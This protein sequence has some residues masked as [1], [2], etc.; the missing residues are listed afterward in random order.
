VASVAPRSC[1]VRSP[2]SP[3][4]TGRN[5][6]ARLT[7]GA[8]IAIVL[9]IGLAI[10]VN[11]FP[12]SQQEAAPVPTETPAPS[13][14]ALPSDTP[15]PATATPRA[16]PTALSADAAVLATADAIDSA[17]VAPP[18]TPAPTETALPVDTP[19]PTVVPDLV[20]FPALAALLSGDNNDSPPVPKLRGISYDAP[21]QTL[22][23]NF[24]MEQNFTD[25]LTRDGLKV[26][27]SDMYIAIFHEDTTPVSTAFL[28]AWTSLVDQYGNTA[29]GPV[30]TTALDATVAHRIN[31]QA[32]KSALELTI[33]PG[34][35]RVIYSNPALGMP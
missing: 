13:P 7:A 23:V 17:T 25:N 19:A 21:T 8:L 33:I 34:L 24:N 12:G 22:T 28:H 27:M 15:A 31:W 2:A 4:P 11:G 16:T 26:H 18:D 1:G 6:A 32:D 35:W 10:G 20:R 9:L 3:A 30:Y 5:V 14:T 29:Y